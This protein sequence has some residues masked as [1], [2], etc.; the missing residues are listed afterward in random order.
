MHNKIYSAENV[1]LRIKWIRK[2]FDLSQTEFAATIDAQITQYNNWEL[3]RQ[4]LSLDGALRINE[5]YGI[6]LDFLFLDRREALP[7]SMIKS[8]AKLP[9]DENN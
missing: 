7:I 9:I 8:L 1:A 2:Y 3:G 5:V 6:S 4:R